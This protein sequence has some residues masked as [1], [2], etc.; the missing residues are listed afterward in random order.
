[1]KREQ[2]EMR[3]QAAV[4]S[5]SASRCFNGRCAVLD[6]ALDLLAK[7]RRVLMPMN[8]NGVLHS[9]LHEARAHCQR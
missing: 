4:V 3:F 9:C 2:S 5:G 6:Y 8:S 7:L 1:M